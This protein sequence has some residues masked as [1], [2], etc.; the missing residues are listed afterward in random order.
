MYGSSDGGKSIKADDAVSI[1]LQK[2]ASHFHLAAH[3]VQGL[4]LYT[5]ADVE[6]HKDVHS[7]EQVFYMLDLARC[8][9]R[10]NAH[11]VTIYSDVQVPPSAIFFRMLRPELLL[12]LKTADV[13]KL[14]ENDETVL[15]RK[16]VLPN[17]E[18]PS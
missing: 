6:V 14:V 4:L 15:K 18:E 9:P 5:A 16:P 11:V 7:E 3:T 1:D 17:L 10:E 13:S 12:K 2:V 8:F